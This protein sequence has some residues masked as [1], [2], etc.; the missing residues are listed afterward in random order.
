[1]SD[2]KT[3]LIRR[4]SNWVLRDYF[5]QAEESDRRFDKHMERIDQNMAKGDKS[6]R[7]IEE[8]IKRQSQP[9]A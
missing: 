9:Q 8:W 6:V 3:A 7:A 2:Q 5:A 4:M 1:M